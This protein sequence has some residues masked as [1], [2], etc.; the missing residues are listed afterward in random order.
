MEAAIIG[1]HLAVTQEESHPFRRRARIIHDRL[2]LTPGTWL[3]PY[4]V[5]A[6]IG[7]GGMGG[8]QGH[9]HDPTVPGSYFCLLAFLLARQ[10]DS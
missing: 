3:G 5:V 8:V 1:K 10:I 4:E 7:G 2:A 9:R 6:Q